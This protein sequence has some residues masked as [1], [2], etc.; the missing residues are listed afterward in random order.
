MPH[1]G[2]ISYHP[3][4]RNPSISLQ[5]Q[6]PGDENEDPPGRY[7]P[8]RCGNPNPTVWLRIG[9]GSWSQR[10]ARVASRDKIEVPPHPGR[11]GSHLVIKTF[12]YGPAAPGE[13]SFPSSGQKSF[14]ISTTPP[15]WGR[16]RK[17]PGSILPR[18]MLKPQ[19]HWLVAD[20]LGLME[21]AGGEP[22]LSFQGQ[23]YAA[24]GEVKVPS[25]DQNSF[26]TSA[27]PTNRE[28]RR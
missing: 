22:C 9:W 17:S 5:L 24:H 26:H 10:A 16:K 28:P 21:P 4:V 25:P 15:T 23:G 14:N 11:I 2:R 6:L 13:D 19:P 1:P 12:P 27:F 18:T 3:R 8:A 7:R 20:W